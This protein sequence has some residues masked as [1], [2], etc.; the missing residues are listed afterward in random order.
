MDYCLV[1]YPK[2]ALFA[3]KM[4]MKF[5][6]EI[7]WETCMEIIVAE[8]YPEIDNSNVHKFPPHILPPFED[9]SCGHRVVT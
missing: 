2:L 7:F 1:Y 5:T 4:E 8:N 6:E 9:V 3:H